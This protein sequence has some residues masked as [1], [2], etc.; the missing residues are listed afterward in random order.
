MEYAVTIRLIEPML[1]TVP[2]DAEVYSTYIESRKPKEISE[3][4]SET[5]DVSEE[6]GW[7][8]FHKD[9]EGYFLYDYI[10]LGFCKEAANILKD[11]LG[12]KALRKKVENYVM[13]KPRRIRL[14][15]PKG[16]LE[17]PL[18]AQTMQG[19]RVTLARSD[20]IAEGTELSFVLDVLGHKEITED[21][22]RKLLEYGTR[23][24][25]GQWRNGGFGRFEVVRF[26][27]SA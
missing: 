6:R 27:P 22:L 18:R 8:G 15:E 21:V 25:L 19:E 2:K 17:R 1:G 4:E 5:V 23:K 12:V 24:G 3:N 9:A 26:Q 14:P 13:V 11:V 7:T 20:Y 16:A 10:V